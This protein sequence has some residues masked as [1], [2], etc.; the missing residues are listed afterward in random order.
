MA[1]IYI[2]VEPTMWEGNILRKVDFYLDD[3]EVS[4]L[5]GVAVIKAQ[6]DGYLA[7]WQD[8]K[9]VEVSTEELEELLE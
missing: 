9:W 8:G 6:C 7:H 2:V 3:K 5:E 4:E 1:D